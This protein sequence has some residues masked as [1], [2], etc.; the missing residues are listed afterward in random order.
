MFEILD[1]MND[2]VGCLVDALCSKLNYLC[3]HL[4]DLV[5]FLVCRRWVLG[6]IGFV[7]NCLEVIGFGYAMIK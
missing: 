6:G 4:C 1:H 3:V 7:R 2:A 5:D